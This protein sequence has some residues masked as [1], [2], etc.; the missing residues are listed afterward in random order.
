MGDQSTL[1]ASG[2][3][4]RQPASF[5]AT[6]SRIAASRA[7]CLQLGAARREKARFI[8]GA[9]KPASLCHGDGGHEGSDR[10]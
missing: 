8:R 5:N 1:R 10:C 7:A 3:P 2:M 9:K 6:F 4:T